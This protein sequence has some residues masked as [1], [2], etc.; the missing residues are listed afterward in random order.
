MLEVYLLFVSKRLNRFKFMCQSI[1]IDRSLHQYAL[2][3]RQIYIELLVGFSVM[4]AIIPPT[5]T[6]GK[7]GQFA[8]DYEKQARP[9]QV[10]AISKAQK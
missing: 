7:A 10:C 3:N 9:A 4:H 8:T 6:T 1:E 5:C 2:K